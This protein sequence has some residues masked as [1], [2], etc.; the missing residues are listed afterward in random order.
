MKALVVGFG[1]IGARHA[2]VLE[3]MGWEVAVVSRRSGAARREY[4]DLATAVPDFSPDYVVIANETAAHRGSV[5]ELASTAFSGTVLVEKPLFD[6]PAPVP[7]HHFRSAFVAYNLR[8]HPLTEKLRA[9][10]TSHR[11][12]A[13]DVYVG[14]HLASWRP[15]TN[16]ATSYSAWRARGGGVLRDL[17][18]EIDYV[19]WVLGPI[20]ELTADG[21]HLST[22]VG[23]SDDV[24]S[25]LART[26]AGAVAAVHLNYLDRNPRRTV[27]LLAS[28]GSITVDY[29]PGRVDVDGKSEVVTVDRDATYRAMHQA[30]VLGRVSALATFD[31]GMAVLGLISAAER[32]AEGRMWIHV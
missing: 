22:L 18:H 21:G 1:S 11:V 6:Q 28:E 9:F 23:D 2:R 27:T 3:E 7:A 14:Q 24:F 15:G 31:D 19:R 10:A 25:L 26:A 17:S 13:A 4:G 12:H 5:E 8:F 30:A 16:Y 32:A 29:V 20:A